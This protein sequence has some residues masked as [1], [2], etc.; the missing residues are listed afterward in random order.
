MPICD[1]SCTHTRLCALASVLRVTSAPPTRRDVAHTSVVDEC[2]PTIAGTVAVDART[3]TGRLRG[4]NGHARFL[5]RRA[6]RVADIRS[7]KTKT[8]D[9]NYIRRI[10]RLRT[11]A[12]CHAHASTNA[13]T[14]NTAY[15]ITVTAYPRMMLDIRMRVCNIACAT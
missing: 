10:P 1:W 13:R 6:T 5:T 3:T 4:N 15:D 11:R 14:N 12:R 2:T 7:L 9:A 8:S